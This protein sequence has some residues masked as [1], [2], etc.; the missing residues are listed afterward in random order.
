MLVLAAAIMSDDAVQRAVWNDMRRRQL[1]LTE[2]LERE[3]ELT[4]QM[5][6]ASEEIEEMQRALSELYAFAV[7]QGWDVP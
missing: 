2:A 6:N 3:R 5:R 1:K 7:K 4:S